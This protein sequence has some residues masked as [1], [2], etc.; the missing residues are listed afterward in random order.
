MTNF[1]VYKIAHSGTLAEV[2]HE[3]NGV[4]GV[5]TL[6][7]S[8][9][10]IHEIQEGEGRKRLPDV[11]AARSTYFFC[12]VQALSLTVHDIHVLGG[13]EQLT[14]SLPKNGNPKPFKQR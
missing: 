14:S 8:L 7:T 1:L 3:S 4:S 9:Y 12:V 11:V 5:Q 6:C 2:I 10:A 13:I